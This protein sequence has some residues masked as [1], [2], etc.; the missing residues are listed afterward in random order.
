MCMSVK[1]NQLSSLP[2]IR[3]VA[4]VNLDEAN[5]VDEEVRTKGTLHHKLRPVLQLS[6][7]LL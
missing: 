6:I 4:I 7:L 5:T 1:Q 3:D 2:I